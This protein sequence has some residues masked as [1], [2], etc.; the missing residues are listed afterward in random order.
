LYFLFE[1]FALIYIPIQGEENIKLEEIIFKNLIYEILFLI[2]K[3]QN[4]CFDLNKDDNYLF[5][6]EYILRFFQNLFFFFKDIKFPKEEVKII[7][8]QQIKDMNLALKT[9]LEINLLKEH[10]FCFEYSCI[11]NKTPDFSEIKYKNTK[12]RLK[13]DEDKELEND[14]LNNQM[15]EKLISFNFKIVKNDI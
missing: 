3:I 7:N 13:T 5:E 2:N 6:D 12:K 15:K 1:I 11:K 8:D 9:S 10:S 14:V 4:F